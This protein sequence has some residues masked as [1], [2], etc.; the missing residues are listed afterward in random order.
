[1]QTIKLFILLKRILWHTHKL[2]MP[3]FN[4]IF[5]VFILAFFGYTKIN[6]Q[7]IISEDSPVE[8]NILKSASLSA[9]IDSALTINA[10]LNN[11]NQLNF[12]E[13]SEKPN[14]SFTSK[15]YWLTFDIHNTT[16]N[17]K[18][19]YLETARPI[20]DNVECYIINAKGEIETQLS[21]DNLPLS[22]K[23]ISHNKTLFKLQLKEKSNYKVYIHYKSDGE[24]LSLPLIIFTPDKFIEQTHNELL[25]FGL[26]YGV[27]LLAA[28]TYLFFYF[29]MGDKSFLYYSLYVIFIALLQFS[30]DGLFHQ[31]IMPGSGWLYLRSLI[32]FALLSSYFMSKYVVTFLKIEESFYY[33]PKIFKAINIALVLVFISVLISPATFEISYPIANLL[34]LLVLAFIILSIV[35]FRIKY[36]K[37]DKLFVTGIACLVIGFTIFILNNMGILPDSLITAYSTKLGTGL[38]II[39]LSLSMAN[40]IW[41]LKSEKEQIQ[42]IALQKSEEANEL[43]ANFMSMMSHE[44]RTPLNAIMGIADVMNKE[45]VNEKIKNN[46]NLIKYS[47]VGLLSAVND[48][49]DF[50]K[51]QKGELKLQSEEFQP[52]IIIDMAK[53]NWQIQAANKNI[54]LKTSIANDLPDTVLGDGGRFTQILNNLLNNAVK[55]TNSGEIKLTVNHQIIQ[56]DKSHLTIIVSDTGIGIPKEKRDSIFESFI[57]ESINDKRQYGGFG[58]GLSI[59]KRLVDMHNGTI[60]MES[61]QNIGTTFT[62]TLPFTIIKNKVA[63]QNSFDKDDFDLQG[64]K[65]LVVEDND[66]NQF[67]MKK[68]FSSW[69]NTEIVIAENGMIAVEKLAEESFDIVL[70]D[71]QMPVMDGYEA[72]QEIRNGAC[73]DKNCSIPI[74]AVTADATSEAKLKAQ[75]VGMNDYMTK[76]IDQVLLYEKITKLLSKIAA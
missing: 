21:G 25:V 69:K 38:E 42:S 10:V 33:L 52:R 35:R 5:L 39:F 30:L 6:A 45:V 16:N 8:I 34:G 2:P 17:L 65:I 72:T 58:I 18:T 4:H 63:P 13:I 41:Q 36:N 27:L 61:E 22:E 44:L 50:S 66:I 15:H 60:E 53:A 32:L 55:S 59:V 73:G 57:Q 71:L 64:N 67:I 40:R 56:D 26:F 49:L 74:I 20:I 29:G 12:K 43:K 24:V 9:P 47:A 28:I 75:N 54:T 14:I 68:I 70:M 23:A 3:N 19:Y 46:F 62:I 48:I 37:V 11:A 31:Y 7:V 51:I 76:P 1:M